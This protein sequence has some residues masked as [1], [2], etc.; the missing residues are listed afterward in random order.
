MLLQQAF[1]NKLFPCHKV[2]VSTNCA[3]IHSFAS[4]TVRHQEE[5]KSAGLA[6]NNCTHNMVLASASASRC[7]GSILVIGVT[8]LMFFALR[9][10]WTGPP[11]AETKEPDG[12][13]RAR[14]VTDTLPYPQRKK[15]VLTSYFIYHE[16][17]KLMVC[18]SPKAASTALRLFFLQETG[19]NATYWSEEYKAWVHDPHEKTGKGATYV[20]T[21]PDPA[22]IL[23]DGTVFKAIFVRDP[24][25]RLQSAYRNKFLKPRDFDSTTRYAQDLC[26]ARCPLSERDMFSLPQWLEEKCKVWTSDRSKSP[27]GVVVV[28]TFKEFVRA[29]GATP[30][31]CLEEHWAHQTRLC[32]VTA[33]F[34]YQFV[35]KFETFQRDASLL[36]ARFALDANKLKKL[37]T[38]NTLVGSE[39]AFDKEMIEIVNLKYYEDIILFDYNTRMP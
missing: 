19:R 27:D 1:T 33:G 14:R 32:G 8:L 23:A 30:P 29:I 3:R 13:A 20:H 6:R 4:I 28:P 5:G 11:H 10:E 9:I 22:K 21:M 2:T 25:T 35:G 34:D 16:A 12:F 31:K 15:P 24:F 26:W 39:L 18:V 7:V 36:F 38:Y 17:K 37:N